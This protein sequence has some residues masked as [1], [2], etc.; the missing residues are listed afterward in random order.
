MKDSEDSL[1]FDQFCEMAILPCYYCGVEYTKAISDKSSTK[2]LMTDEVIRC[3]GID[4]IDSKKHYTLANCRP[5]CFN[6][7]RTKS[8]REESE[9]Y[10]WIERIYKNLVK[11]GIL[12][13]CA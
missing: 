7:N 4:R 10:E 12:N 2:R 13:V 9:Y 6:C 11:R 5:C 8:N 3:N 1:T